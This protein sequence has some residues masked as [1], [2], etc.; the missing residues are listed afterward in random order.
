MD[1]KIIKETKS[2][3]GF[4]KIVETEYECPCGQGKVSLYQENM[5]G[6]YDWSAKIECADCNEK[7]ELTWGKG[8]YPGHSPMVRI[9]T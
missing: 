9:K 4:G 8:V 2:D 7:Y 3:N 6:Y 5:S 1:L